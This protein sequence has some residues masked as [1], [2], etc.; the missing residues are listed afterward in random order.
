M[1]EICWSENDINMDI[2]MV[3]KGF[4]VVCSQRKGIK[5]FDGKDDDDEN[6]DFYCWSTPE[7]N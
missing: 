1:S 6:K 5:H 4:S 2:S 3:F 7:H